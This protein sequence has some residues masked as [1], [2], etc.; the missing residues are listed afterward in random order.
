MA[1]E[2]KNENAGG[3]GKTE[4]VGKPTGPSTPASAPAAS[5]ASTSTAPIP[6]SI[7][8]T[9]DKP[10]DSGNLATDGRTVK[11]EDG[12]DR[13]VTG[14]P[15]APLTQVGD[16]E[17]QVTNRFG[18]TV[19]REAKP[20]DLPADAKIAPVAEQ[21]NPN[22]ASQAV[23]AAPTP[24]QI[25]GVEQPEEGEKNV[26]SDSSDSTQFLSPESDQHDE[27][28]RADEDAQRYSDRSTGS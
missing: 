23:G 18:G 2:T 26:V 16:P 12:N 22:A 19:Q 10:A 8:E 3:E 11:D 15:D 24:E 6:Q 25:A 28:E 5:P 4:T 14:D 21:V 9:T 1:D 7:S 27:A 20:E 17:G 13:R